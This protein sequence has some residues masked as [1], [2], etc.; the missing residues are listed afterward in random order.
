[1]HIHELRSKLNPIEYVGF[2]KGNII[3]HILSEKDQKEHLLKVRE[4]LDLMFELYQLDV[5][6]VD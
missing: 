6:S 4:Y 2:L 3:L 5:L 1:M